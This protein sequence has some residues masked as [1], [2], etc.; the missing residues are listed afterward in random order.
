MR[1]LLLLQTALSEV[2]IEPDSAKRKD[3]LAFAAD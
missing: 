3:V 1:L 2:L